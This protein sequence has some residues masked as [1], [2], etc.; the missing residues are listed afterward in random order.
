VLVVLVV[1]VQELGQLVLET[2]E[3]PILVVVQVAV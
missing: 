1:E 3:L 2:T